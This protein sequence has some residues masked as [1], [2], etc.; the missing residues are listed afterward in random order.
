MTTQVW[1]GVIFA[2]VVV[3]FLM[4]AYFGPP[5]DAGRHAII[6][7]LCALCAGCAGGFLAGSA[8]FEYAQNL[9]NGGKI[10]FT[11]VA[12]FGLFGLVLLTFPGHTPPVGEDTFNISFP[13]GTTFQDAAKTV[14]QRNSS[15]AILEGFETAEKNTL[16]TGTLNGT[17][18]DRHV[19]VLRRLGDLAATS[20]RPYTVTFEGNAYLL[21]V[22]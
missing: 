2:G 7:F 3:L 13:A 20:I 4:L 12:G 11:G 9:P 21:K 16:V 18:A 1:I 10:A 6:R 15:V 14:A 8:L 19:Q 22:S 5:M 17:G